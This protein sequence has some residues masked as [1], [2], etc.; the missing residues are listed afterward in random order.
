MPSRLFDPLPD[1]AR[2]WIHASDR[3]LSAEEQAGT[4][5]ALHAFIAGWSSHGRK[6]EGMA[7][8]VKNRFVI[9]GAYVPGGD[10]SGCGID[11]S[12]HALS[13]IAE[14]VGF[15]WA[16]ALDVFFARD[17]RVEQADRIAFA[18]M[19]SRGDVTPDTMVYDTSLTTLDQW[20]SEGFERL[21]RTSWHGRVFRLQ[22]ETV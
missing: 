7:S 9:I 15:G 12:V 13:G 11:A 1:S 22:T 3:D 8:I 19:A 17:G 10:I 20:R 5:E 14:E 4:I 21:A 6:V 18:E 16:P 2:I